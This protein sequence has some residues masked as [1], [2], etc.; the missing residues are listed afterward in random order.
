[1]VLVPSSTAAVGVVLVGVGTLVYSFVM[2]SNSVVVRNSGDSVATVDWTLRFW[3]LKLLNGTND[4]RNSLCFWLE[5]LALVIDSLSLFIAK[6]FLSLLSSKTFRRLVGL[7]VI[8]V[9]V[10]GLYNI[11]AILLSVVCG[12]VV[13]ATVVV[14]GGGLEV[15]VVVVVVVVLLMTGEVVGKLGPGFRNIGSFNRS[16]STTL[17]SSQF[18][19]GLFTIV[20]RVLELLRTENF[21]KGGFNSLMCEK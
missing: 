15:V 7:C 20:V 6:S 11:S 2:C 9:V 16:M 12:T 1:M 21:I 3:N 8:G 14:L 17:K 4:L 18:V 5:N 10:V 13:G 19:L